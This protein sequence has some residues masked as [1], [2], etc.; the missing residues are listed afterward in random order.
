MN[1]MRKRERDWGEL[2]SATKRLLSQ[3]LWE[4]FPTNC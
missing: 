2:V 4:R 3:T 1:L